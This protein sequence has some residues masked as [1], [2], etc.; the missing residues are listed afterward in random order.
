MHKV[1]K[2]VDDRWL[3]KDLKAVAFNRIEQEFGGYKTHRLEICHTLRYAWLNHRFDQEVWDAIK[4]DAPSEAFSITQKF[5]P[6][7]VS[8]E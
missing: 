1:M 2:F 6:E 5:K 8:F 3:A 7:D 4:K